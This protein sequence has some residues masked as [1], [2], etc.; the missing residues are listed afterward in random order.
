MKFLDE[1]RLLV[2]SGLYLLYAY[3]IDHVLIGVLREILTI[4]FLLAQVFFL[5]LGI[6]WLVKQKYARPYRTVLSV[7]LLAICTYLAIG[8]F[9]K[10]K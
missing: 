2:I 3:K 9:F 1:K 10:A 4:P 5:I 6:T 7:S 8:S